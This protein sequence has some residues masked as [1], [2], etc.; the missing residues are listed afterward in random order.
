MG[1][2]VKAVLVYRVAVASEPFWKHVIFLYRPCEA[3]IVPAKELLCDES[4][5]GGVSDPIG[6]VVS[7]RKVLGKTPRPL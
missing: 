6:A 2:E 1:L 7:V 4:L 3:S 5:S